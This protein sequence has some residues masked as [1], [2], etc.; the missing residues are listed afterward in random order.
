MRAR[1]ENGCVIGL[2]C[3]LF[4]FF[5][6]GNDRNQLRTWFGAIHFGV[7]MTP[8]VE[9]MV[10]LCLF[11]GLWLVYVWLFWYNEYESGMFKKFVPQ[12]EP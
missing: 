4:L 11:V 7:S 6:E 9:N 2:F 12:T 8:S 5:W 10:K 3:V 1:I